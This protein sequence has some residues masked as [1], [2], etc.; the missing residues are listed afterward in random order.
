MFSVVDETNPPVSEIEELE[1]L[2]SAIVG[3]LGNQKFD[4]YLRYYWNSFNRTVGKKHLF[5]EIKKHITTKREV[6]DLELV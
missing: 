2:W 5:K 4:D 1:Y 6:F 3:K